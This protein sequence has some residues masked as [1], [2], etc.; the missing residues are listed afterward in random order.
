[1]DVLSLFPAANLRSGAL[2]P[3][4]FRDELVQYVKDLQPR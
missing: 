1:M 2:N 4:P 3:Y